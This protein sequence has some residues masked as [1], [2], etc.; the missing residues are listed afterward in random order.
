MENIFTDGL[1]DFGLPAVIDLI[2]VTGLFVFLYRALKNTIAINILIGMIVMI[3]LRSVAEAIHLKVF[4]WILQM[5]SDVWL[6]AFIILFQPEIRKL[7]TIVMRSSLFNRFVKQDI[8]EKL[9]EVIEAVKIMSDQHT[10][11]LIVFSKSQ[12]VQMTID[13]GVQ[14][15]SEISKE[16][17]LA[18]FNT[19][20]PLHDGA[21]IID[22]Q[23]ITSAKCILPLSNQKRYGDKI[24]GT[25]HRAGLGL[26]EKIDAVVLIISEE[27]K[28]IS[29]AFSGELTFDIPKENIRKVLLDKFDI[30]KQRIFS[31]EAE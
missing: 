24:L 27:T 29:I 1:L 7:L 15:K 10:G 26:S 30:S 11:A 4:S 22:N 18:I 5:V 31:D 9:D 21:I 23:M 2:L 13:H 16:L 3:A 17:I 12:D 19:K 6:I 14:I 28:A 8:N 25:R 20:S